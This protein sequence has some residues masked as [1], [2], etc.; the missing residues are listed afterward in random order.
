MKHLK[1]LAS[2][3]VASALLFGAAPASAIVLLTFGQVGTGNTITGTNVGGVST[4]ISGANVA[5]T[6]TQIDAAVATP[7]AASLTLNATSVGAATL[8]AGNVVQTFS[9]SF[10]ITSGATNYLSGTF[11][12]AVFG[13]AGGAA[14]TLSA[15]QPPDT[16]S[17]TS[18][19][20]AA[21]DLG[22]A[23]GISFSFANVS[24]PVGITGTSLSSFASSVSGT[25]SG[26]VGTV[27]E[28]ATLGLLGLALAGLG[29]V[30][31]R[32]QA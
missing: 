20:I 4:T 8:V 26:N 11:S 9:G 12:D 30:R 25:F 28:P 6:I 15:A 29:F 23:R 18:N 24:P 21:G 13:A 1:Q 10:S 17:F 31:T 14:L 16:V 19:V 2:A 22:L 32:K 3:L 7:I 27:P 5:V